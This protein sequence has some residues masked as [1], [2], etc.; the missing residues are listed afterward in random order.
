MVDDLGVVFVL[1]YEGFLVFYDVDGGFCVVKY[2]GG[3]CG[4][5]VFVVFKGVIS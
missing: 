4:Y 5:D 3:V 1:D 2:F